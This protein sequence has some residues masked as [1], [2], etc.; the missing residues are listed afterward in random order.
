MLVLQ[1]ITKDY[2]M[3]DTRVHALRG[4]SLAF[5]EHEFV[6]ILGPS[7]CGKTTLLN[8]ISGLD[9]YTGEIY[10]SA[11]GVPPDSGTGTGTITG[12]IP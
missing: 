1:E 7:G 9:R 3:G 2:T 11:A 12:T 5:R 10:R 6:A 4:V 8:L